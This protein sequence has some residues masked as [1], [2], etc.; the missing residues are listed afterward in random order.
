MNIVTSQIEYDQRYPNVPLERWRSNVIDAVTMIGDKAHQESSWLREDRPAWE[1]PNEIINVLFDDVR[2]ELFLKDCDFSFTE[3]Q[4]ETA[5]SLSIMLNEFLDNTP[6]W[7]EPI[8]T[9]KDQRWEEIRIAARNC[10]VAF[11]AS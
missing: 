2:F 7:L 10:V 3:S 11:S 6:Q 4:R 1:N 8:E 9:L 5:Q